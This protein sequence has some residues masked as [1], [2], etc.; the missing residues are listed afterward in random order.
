VYER[1]ALLCVSDGE[2]RSE[3]EHFEDGEVFVKGIGV[4]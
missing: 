2:G 3:L 4:V 1:A